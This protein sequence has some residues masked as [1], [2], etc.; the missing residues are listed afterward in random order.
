[1]ENLFLTNLPIA[2]A[3]EAKTIR[4]A[5]AWAR[6]L[7]HAV[8]TTKHWRQELSSSPSLTRHQLFAPKRVKLLDERC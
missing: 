5:S 8:A 2:R 1:M 4:E 6:Q 7:Q 3:S